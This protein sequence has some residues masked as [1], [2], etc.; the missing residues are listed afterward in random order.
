MKKETEDTLYSLIMTGLISGVVFQFIY[1]KTHTLDFTFNKFLF[2]FMLYEAISIKK[3][4]KRVQ[5]DLLNYSTY[6]KLY[7]DVKFGSVN[8]DEL[9]DYFQKLVEEVGKK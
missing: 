5:Q 7:L 1:L 9:K 3:L 8:A 6:L 2:V 4:F